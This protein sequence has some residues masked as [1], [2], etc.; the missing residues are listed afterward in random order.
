MEDGCHGDKRK[1]G[2]GGRFKEQ[3]PI[4]THQEPGLLVAVKEDEDLALGFKERAEHTY[5]AV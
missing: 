3:Y 2:S 4:L 5:R 1:G